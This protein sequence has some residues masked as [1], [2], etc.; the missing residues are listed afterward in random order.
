MTG[1]LGQG[2]LAAPP[3][4]SRA[5]PGLVPA[6]VLAALLVGVLVVVIASEGASSRLAA[7]GGAS[8]HPSSASSIGRCGRS[9]N[10][11]PR[12]PVSNPLV[13]WCLTRAYACAR[14]S[15]GRPSP[16]TESRSFTCGCGE[17]QLPSSAQS[18]A[19][20]TLPATAAMMTFAS[21]ELIIRIVVRALGGR[22]YSAARAGARWQA[23]ILAGGRRGLEQL[24]VFGRG[25]V[26]RSHQRPLLG[27]AAHPAA[28]VDTD[29]GR[30]L[31]LGPNDARLRL[32]QSGWPERRRGRGSCC[33]RSR[34]RYPRNHRRRRRGGRHRSCCRGTNPRRRP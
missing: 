24:R 13:E 17:P 16:Y 10:I 29:A 34:R 27:R 20:S 6:L 11:P 9:M 32:C 26:A 19:I 2:G 30:P 14:S 7:G 23:G 3:P 12:D 28:F 1:S 8:H 15:A 31:L 22:A 4:A 25:G 18:A 5:S 21:V 33:P